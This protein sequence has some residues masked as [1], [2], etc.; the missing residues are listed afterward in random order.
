MNHED[1]PLSVI[2]AG[3][4]RDKDRQ[5]IK[6]K[7]AVSV[8]F[9]LVFEIIHEIMT[10]NINYDLEHI[11]SLSE[12]WRFVLPYISLYFLCVQRALNPHVEILYS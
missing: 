3:K 12:I 1:V 9:M 4:L 7:F 6:E 8:L 5:L 10:F 2:Q 11:H